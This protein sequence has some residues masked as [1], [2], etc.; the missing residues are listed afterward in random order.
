[1]RTT[2]AVRATVSSFPARLLR[3]AA[4]SAF[5]LEDSADSGVRSSTARILFFPCRRIKLPELHYVPP[6]E[7]PA[8]AGVNP[9]GDPHALETVDQMASAAHVVADSST[10][11]WGGHLAP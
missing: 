11:A 5:R 8:I 6:P 10:G 3:Q 9:S 4:A 7:R 1:M 2:G